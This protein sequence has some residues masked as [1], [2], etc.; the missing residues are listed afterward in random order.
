M[1]F[2]RALRDDGAY[3][4]GAGKRDVINAF[5]VGQC[6]ARFMA[7][8]CDDVQR[9]VREAAISGELRNAQQ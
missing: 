3:T 8:A 4:C 9:T 6:L 1:A 2:R 7:V 5:G